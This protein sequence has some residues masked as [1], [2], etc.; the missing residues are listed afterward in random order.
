MTVRF[1]AYALFLKELPLLRSSGNS[2]SDTVDN[3]VAGIDSGGST[4]H[5]P[6]KT[7]MARSID[8]VRNLTVAHYLTTG[9]SG[10]NT[11]D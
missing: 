4:E 8:E 3:T 11:I 7:G 1:E 6:H 10:N 2:A 5:M 9:N